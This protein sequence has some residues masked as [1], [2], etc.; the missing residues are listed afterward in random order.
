[1]IVAAHST[2]LPLL[3]PLPEQEVNLFLFCAK[4]KGR[5]KIKIIENKNKCE[6]MSK[7]MINWW[8]TRGANACRAQRSGVGITKKKEKD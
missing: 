8:R 7:A 3:L 5:K 1:M 2:L 6:P 4:K